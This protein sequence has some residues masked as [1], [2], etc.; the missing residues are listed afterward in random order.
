MNEDPNLAGPDPYQQY[1]SAAIW[2]TVDN[3]INELVENNDLVEMTARR[4]IV[5]YII[6]CLS[7]AR[8]RSKEVRRVGMSDDSD[9][10][11]SHPYEKYEN[12]AI[13]STVDNAITDLVANNDLVE[14]T[15]RPYIVGSPIKC[16]TDAGHVPL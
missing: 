11:W 2:V 12:T 14:T 16:L 1:E 7:E 6:K 8:H 15:A 5:G 9:R 3:E 13:W 4:H 10:L